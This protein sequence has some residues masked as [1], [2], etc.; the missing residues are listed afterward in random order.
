MP[1][2]STRRSAAARAATQIPSRD[3]WGRLTTR[4][5]GRGAGAAATVFIHRTT[6]HLRADTHGPEGAADR[7]YATPPPRLI[8]HCLNCATPRPCVTWTERDG[9][10]DCVRHALAPTGH[11]THAECRSEEAADRSTPTRVRRVQPPEAC[12]SSGAASR[13][14]EGLGDSS[15]RPAAARAGVLRSKLDASSGRRSGQRAR[16]R[17]AGSDRAPPGALPAAATAVPLNSLAATIALEIWKYR[18]G[19]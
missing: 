17:P 10:L 11:A 16:R 13:G 8:C 1:I 14:K 18:R 9:P 3:R 15:Q 12:S 2:P 7:P 19:A 4:A 5:A 6:S